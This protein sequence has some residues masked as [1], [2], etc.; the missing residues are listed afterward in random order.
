MADGCGLGRAKWMAENNYTTFQ[1]NHKLGIYVKAGSVVEDW[2]AKVHDAHA[3]RGFRYIRTKA[4]LSSGFTNVSA[5]DSDDVA[6]QKLTAALEA[7]VIQQDYINNYTNNTPASFTY[8][9]IHH[10]KKH[11]T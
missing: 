6:L 4:T 7:Q 11:F 3:E 2:M 5:T 10:I 8:S 1:C 9:I